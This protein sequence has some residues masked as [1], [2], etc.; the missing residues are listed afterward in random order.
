MQCVC[1]AQGVL[2]L[3]A[4]CGLFLKV[5]EIV[6]SESLTQVHDFLFEAYLVDGIDVPDV[7][8]YDD[9]C[10]LKMWFLNRMTSKLMQHIARVKQGLFYIVV[11]RAPM[12]PPARGISALRERCSVWSDPAC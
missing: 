4:A 9:A 1:L 11:D 5:S 8:A 12:P 7:L 2:A 6:G 10:H 3:V